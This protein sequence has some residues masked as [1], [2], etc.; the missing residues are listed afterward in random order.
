MTLV[1]GFGLRRSELWHHLAGEVGYFELEPVAR[2]GVVARAFFRAYNVFGLR[3]ASEPA[4]TGRRHPPGGAA[5]E[6]V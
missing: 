3:A 1:W 5:L 6:A 4:G 2:D